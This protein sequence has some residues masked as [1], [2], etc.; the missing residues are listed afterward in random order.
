MTKHLVYS[1]MLQMRYK[2]GVGGSNTAVVQS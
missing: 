2:V 1:R